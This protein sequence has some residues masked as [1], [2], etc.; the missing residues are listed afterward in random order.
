MKYQALL[1]VE[2]EMLW[3]GGV[4]AGG[5]WGTGGVRLTGWRRIGTGWGGEEWAD[6]VSGGVS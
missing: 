2:G 6:A 4:D 1:L 3:N 5:F